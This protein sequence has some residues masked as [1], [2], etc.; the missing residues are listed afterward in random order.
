[1]GRPSF[2]HAWNAFRDVKLPVTLVGQKIGGKVQQNIDARIFRNACPI[3][4]SYV[5]N[6]TGFPIAHMGP[7][8]T[9][10]G[11]D[12]RLYIYRVNDMLLYLERTLGKP[13]KIVTSPKPTDFSG[14]KGII[15]VKGHGWKDAKG[16]VT[17]WDGNR[18][19][20]QCHLLND[21]DNGAFVPETAAIWVLQ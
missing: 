5:L 13:D 2:N 6:H 17:L 16:H 14:M 7:Y 18:C 1:M 8:A 15:V 11:A 4:M 21:P 10:T 19:S 20:D 9:V 3:R 12:K